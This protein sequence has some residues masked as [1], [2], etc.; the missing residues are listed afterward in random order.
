MLGTG[1]NTWQAEIDAAVEVI[2]FYRLNTKWAEGILAQQPTEHAFGNWNKLEYRPLEGF[3]F[4]LTPFN[5]LAIGANLP[6]A[7]ALMGNTVVWKPSHTSS[8][9]N[10]KLFQIL[11]RAGL[12]D[13][14]INFVPGSGPVV[15]AGT[16]NHPKFAG[17]H[18]TGSTETFNHLWVQIAGNLGK[19]GQYPRIVGETGGKNFH[20][21]HPS[22]DVDDVV[23][24]TI[25]GAFEY[26]G[27]KCSATS[28]AYFPSNLWPKI[29]EKFQQELKHIKQGQ[30]D[31]FDVFI[32]SVIDRPAFKKITKAIENAKKDP[33]CT[34]IAGGGYND[35][36]GFFIEPTII[37]TTDPHYITMKEE[38]FGPV[39]TVYVYDEKDFAKTLPLVDTTTPYALTGSIFSRDRAGIIQA[40]EGLRNSAGNFYVNDKCTGAVVGQQPFGGARA[41]GTNDKAGSAANLTRWVSM[42]TIKETFLPL[43]TWRY[44]HMSS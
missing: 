19:Y 11:R 36:E 9:G 4:A 30:P 1:K 17:L 34:I 27:Q 7:P 23:N 40:H 3:V 32:T 8:L 24:Q 21:V 29:K 10:W 14:V 18:F 35:S 33:S 44:P 2:D 41:S 38:L 43:S 26:S 42:R 5:F 22:A 31:D 12:P 20:M 39:L 15:G 16:I 6:G 25:R 28:R 37:Q 13:G